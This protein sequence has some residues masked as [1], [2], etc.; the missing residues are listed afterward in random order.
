MVD[1]VSKSLKDKV[2]KEFQRLKEEEDIL[3]K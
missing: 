3:K 2:R 1:T